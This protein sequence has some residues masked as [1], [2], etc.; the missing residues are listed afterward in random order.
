MTAVL[1]GVLL[2]LC[3]SSLLYLAR[4]HWPADEDA[5]VLQINALLPQT[6]CAQC[7]HPGCLPYARAI[8]LDHAPLDRCPPGGTQT[9]AAL[10]RLLPDHQP[11][12]PP[13]QPA[14]QIARID[15]DRCIGC[16][17]C[18]QACPVDAIVGAKGFLHAVLTKDCTGCGLCVAP[19]PVDCID[20][21]PLVPR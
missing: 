5:L 12:Q 15:E 21:E 18:I 10:V 1:A 9:H 2:L 20:L 8:A 4:R 19:C 3:I 7:G 16:Y 17:L 13:V 11:G 6:Q 14:E